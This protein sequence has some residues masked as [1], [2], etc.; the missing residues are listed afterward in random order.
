MNRAGHNSLG[1]RRISATL[2]LHSPS[3]SIASPVHGRHGAIQ[4]TRNL[5]LL[6][7][8]HPYRGVPP[9]NPLQPPAGVGC[10]VIS[11]GTCARRG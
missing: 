8:T 4:G 5:D 11:T 9:N 1:S 7:V 3:D 2:P 10:G 6:V